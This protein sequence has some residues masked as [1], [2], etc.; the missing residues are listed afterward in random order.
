MLVSVE[1][2]LHSPVTYAGVWGDWCVGMHELAPG[3][4]GKVSRCLWDCVN[5]HNI[6]LVTAGQ[7]LPRTA[8]FMSYQTPSTLSYCCLSETILQNRC[9]FVQRLLLLLCLASLLGLCTCSFAFLCCLPVCFVTFQ[10]CY[11]FGIFMAAWWE[12]AGLWGPAEQTE[13]LPEMCALG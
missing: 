6:W 12:V 10:K 11:P 13:P 1:G 9:C 3:E 7:S 5:A 2:P 8:A 4:E